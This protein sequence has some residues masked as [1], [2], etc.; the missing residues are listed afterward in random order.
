MEQTINKTDLLTGNEGEY[1][2]IQYKW[3]KDENGHQI[4]TLIDNGKNYEV[5]KTDKPFMATEPDMNKYYQAAVKHCIE[6]HLDKKKLQ[7][8]LDEVTKK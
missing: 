7:A 1:L 3:S 5:F 6:L 8:K 2:G 4:L